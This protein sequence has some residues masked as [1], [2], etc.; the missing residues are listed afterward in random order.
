M[1]TICIHASIL[2]GILTVA[3]LD[4]DLVLDAGIKGAMDGEGGKGFGSCRDI[5]DFGDVGGYGDFG[6]I[7]SDKRARVLGYSATLT[8]APRLTE[9]IN[10]HHLVVKRLS[11]THRQNSI[12]SRIRHAKAIVAQPITVSMTAQ[13]IS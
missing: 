5:G 12:T 13:Q 2:L 10:P 1:I 8:G 11:Q 4:E 7:T 3:K 6:G 9:G